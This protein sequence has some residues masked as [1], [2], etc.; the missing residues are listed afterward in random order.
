MSENKI[1]DRYEA[2]ESGV[3]RVNDN[4][5]CKTCKFS[6]KLHSGKSANWYAGSCEKYSVKPT[7]V[8][9]DGKPCPKY[10]QK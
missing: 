9:F 5:V 2:E 4:A 6:G 3:M 7:S 10:I 1:N 8:Y